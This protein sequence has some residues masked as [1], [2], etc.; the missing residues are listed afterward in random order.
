MKHLFQF[1][2]CE[3]ML[4]HPNTEKYISVVETTTTDCPICGSKG[5]QR[6]DPFQGY[7]CLQEGNHGCWDP[8]EPIIIYNDEKE[9]S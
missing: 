9:I 4:K 6:R 5:F 3:W 1:I 8:G 2:T 7:T